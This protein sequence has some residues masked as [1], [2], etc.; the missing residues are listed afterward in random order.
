MCPIFSG[1]FDGLQ[2]PSHLH[3]VRKTFEFGAEVLADPAVTAETNRRLAQIP[4]ATDPEVRGLDAYWSRESA[5]RQLVGAGSSY[6]RYLPGRAYTYRRLAR[7]VR[8]VFGDGHVLDVGS[9]SAVLSRY[10]DEDQTYTALDVSKGAL[11]FARELAKEIHRQLGLVRGSAGSI[12][13]ATASVD[14]VVS[15]GLLEHFEFH[16]QAAVIGEMAR[17]A[18]RG[19]IVV[20]PN[21]ECAI[22]KTMCALEEEIAGRDLSFPMEEHY[23]VVDFARLAEDVD[24]EI[25]KVGAFHLAMPQFVPSRF[26]SPEEAGVLTR[27]L[28]LA[29]SAYSGAPLSA[30]E[31]AEDGIDADLVDKYGWFK[32]FAFR[33][34]SEEG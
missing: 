21:T 4:R 15:L 28:A 29:Q 11:L 6:D 32:L 30:W 2:V 18:R 3:M 16:E 9:G 31:Q 27:V 7:L 10:V 13:L 8:E 34:K 17:V 19:A 33:R 26:L 25:V 22:F 23:N 20:V 24:V 1:A 14:V 5:I 12:P